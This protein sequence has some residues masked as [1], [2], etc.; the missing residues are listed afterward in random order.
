MTVRPLCA[1]LLA[2]CIALPRASA[3]NTTV[4]LGGLVLSISTS[5]T[6]QLFHI[7][8]QLSQWDR[9]AH[10]QY[11][12]WAVRSL[13]LT[14]EDSAALR[15]HAELRKARGWSH[16]FEQAFLT[17]LPI[18]A[19]ISNAVQTGLLTSDEAAA[20]GAILQRFA[21]KLAPLIDQQMPRLAGLIAQIDRDRARLNPII[22]QLRHFAMTG[23]TVRVPVFL[24][25]NPDSLNGGGEANGGRLVVEVPIPDP[26]GTLLHESLHFLLTPQQR[27]I[28]AWADSARISP[29]MLN[30]GIAYAL[31]PGLTDDPLK[32]D[33][34]ADIAAGFLARGTPATD[35]YVQSN[36]MALTIRPLLRAA[37]EH[38]ETITAFLPRAVA[39]WRLVAPH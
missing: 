2:V 26:E 29:T 3:Q 16:G 20:E 30:E 1:A 37:L 15:R 18:D 8:D 38:D 36:M 39:K 31:S 32:D 24:I 13:P 35:P 25:A 23:D 9:Y 10:R 22:T 5:R 4:D 33:H 21:P 34:L 11:V 12:R 27:L 14:Q 7:V 28:Q 6:A 17:D 19:A